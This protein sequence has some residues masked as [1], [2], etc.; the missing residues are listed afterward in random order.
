MCKYAMSFEQFREA[1]SYPDGEVPASNVRDEGFTYETTNR[2]MFPD[3][4][5]ESP[6]SQYMT[7]VKTGWTPAAGYCFSGCMEKDGL[8]YYSVVMGGE[9]FPYKDGERVVQGDFVDTIEL[10]SLTEGLKAVGPDDVPEDM[11]VTSL[12]GAGSFSVALPE[13]AKLLVKEGETVTAEYDIPSMVA[14]TV[15]KG[16]PVGTV[17]L[18]AGDAERTFDLEAQSLRSVSPLIIAAVVI[19]AAAV[20]FLVLRARKKKGGRQ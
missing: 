17:T 15:Q 8:V 12:L 3:D 20:V 13:E 14:G 5:Y 6:Y 4:R 11:T 18:K 9:E 16:D 7:G 10:Y 2:V 19:I 1:V